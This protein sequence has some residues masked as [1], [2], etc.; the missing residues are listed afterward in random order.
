MVE[1]DQDID[2][3]LCDRLAARVRT[4]EIQATQAIAI[5]VVQSRFELRK[6]VAY[7][8]AHWRAFLDVEESTHVGN[9]THH[10]WRPAAPR[11]S[12]ADRTIGTITS[13]R[14][15]IRPSTPHP[16]SRRASS[17]V[18]TVHTWTPSPAPWAASTKR[19]DTTCVRPDHSGTW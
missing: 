17:S 4:E 9:L 16:S 15:L 18:S 6:K 19:G 1:D 3:R 11:G 12:L 10:C 2:V 8:F 14:S 7:A 5:E 13:G